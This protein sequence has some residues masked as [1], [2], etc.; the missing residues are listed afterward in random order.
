MSSLIMANCFVSELS[1]WRLPAA[2]KQG[3]VHPPQN[4]P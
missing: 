2:E 4:N 3:E 1:A